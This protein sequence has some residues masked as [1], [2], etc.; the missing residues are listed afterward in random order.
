MTRLLAQL[1]IARRRGDLA[2]VRILQVRLAAARRERGRCP[3]PECR[4]QRQPGWAMCA[5]HSGALLRRMGLA[6]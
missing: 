4:R 6:A 2:A 5:D 1:R 3:V